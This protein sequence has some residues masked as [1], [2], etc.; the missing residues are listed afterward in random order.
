MT[1]DFLVAGF[2]KCGT[3]TIHNLLQQNTQIYLP[4][5]KETFYFSDTSLYTDK[6]LNL[7]KEFYGGVSRGQ[8]IGG[9]EPSFYKYAGRVAPY[10]RPDTKVIFLVRN[11]IDYLF[12]FYKMC[13]SFGVVEWCEAYKK[14]GK[15]SGIVREYVRFSGNECRLNRRSSIIA[16]VIAGGDYIRFIKRYEKLAGRENIKIILFEDFIRDEKKITQEI[17]RFIG[18]EEQQIKTDVAKNKSE[19]IMPNGKIGRALLAYREYL[20]HTYVERRKDIGKNGMAL[21]ELYY[22]YVPKIAS[23]HIE[24][25]IDRSARK[26][27][28]RYYDA[29]V[30]ELAEWMERDLTKEWKW[31]E[32]SQ[33]C[34]ICKT[35][36]EGNN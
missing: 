15:F 12:S 10:M 23:K 17:F 6:E 34:K 24:D 33:D 28:Y 36:L 16:S 14:Y 9:V 7:E 27:L 22:R 3:T 19:E 5:C 25:W 13:M 1:Y 26:L 35:D 31:K 4:E 18:A 11:P 32:E 2:P 30:R 8:I 21:C 29:G 20:H